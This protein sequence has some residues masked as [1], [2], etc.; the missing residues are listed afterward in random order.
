MSHFAQGFVHVQN[1][2]KYNS[3]HHLHVSDSLCQSLKQGFYFRP[4][5]PQLFLG[6]IR[7]Y[8][9][10]ACKRVLS[11]WALSWLYSNTF[12]KFYYPFPGAATDLCRGALILCLTQG[13]LPASPTIKKLFLFMYLAALGLTCSMQDL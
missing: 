11:H 6:V 5:R 1:T 2:Q 13:Y 4:V 10:Y 3:K 9:T 7:R 8:S 12:T